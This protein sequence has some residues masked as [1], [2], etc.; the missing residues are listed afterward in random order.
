MTQVN[1][2]IALIG[3]VLMLAACS[4]HPGS[5]VWLPS[6]ENNSGYSKM[7]VQFDGRVEFFATDK[8]DAIARCFWAGEDGQ[9]LS[10]DCVMADNSEMTFVYYL[11]V[12]GSK[13]TAELKKS[14]ELIGAF[15][16]TDLNPEP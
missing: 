14:G 4:P 6:G 5:G 16:R 1:K 2:S 7:V 9:N 11:E 3:L 10:M 15:S 8:T 12:D 13:K